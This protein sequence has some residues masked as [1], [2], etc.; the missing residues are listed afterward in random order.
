MKKQIAVVGLGRFGEAVATT[1]Q[2]QG[3]EVLGVDRDGALVQRLSGALTH[4]VQADCTE[5]GTIRRL[6][7]HNFDVVVVAI[8][9]DLEASILTTVLLKEDGVPLV[10]AKASTTQHGKVLAK[11]GADRVIFP[12]RDSGHRL[13]QSLLS[14][15]MLDYI[16]LAPGYQ[17]MELAAGPE[18]CGHSLKELRLRNRLGVNVIAIKRGDRVDAMP[19]AN[20]QIRQGDVLVVIGPTAGLRRLDSV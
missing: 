16:D 17:V 7:L 3:C 11:I 4:V 9:T 13:A 10:V 19:D 20:D 5:E 6:G 8:G 18:L 12:E 15:T 14:N 1:L 2:R